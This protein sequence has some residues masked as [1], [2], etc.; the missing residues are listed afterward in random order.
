MWDN[1]E[2]PR[3]SHL[4]ERFRNERDPRMTTHRF[5]FLTGTGSIGHVNMLVGLIRQLK[6]LGHTVGW[7]AQTEARARQLED[8][9][10]DV[11]R[12]QKSSR[13][14]PND[15]HALSPE[16]FVH[17]AADLLFQEDMV[18]P[19][20]DAIR[21]FVPD[22]MAIDC[23]SFVGIVAAALERVPYV[24]VDTMLLTAS[25]MGAGDR[26]TRIAELLKPLR[27]TFFEK[28]GVECTM[29]FYEC[30]SP[31]LNLV[32]S[33]KEFVGGGLDA[34]PNT[35]FVG[36][37]VSMERPDTKQEF[38]WSELEGHSNLGFC[39]LGT[40][41]ETRVP[42][43]FR[44]AAEAMAAMGWKLV[45]S[46]GRLTGTPTVSALPGDPLVVRY[47]PQPVLLRRGCKL[48]IT[49]GGHNS[50]MEALCAGVPM[51]VLPVE[52]DQFLNGYLVQRAGLGL[53]IEAKDVTAEG[54]QDAV[55]ALARPIY[56]QRAKAF[57]EK[58]G[59]LDGSRESANL[60]IAI[61]NQS[62][63]G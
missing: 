39:S 1:G 3:V 27:Q 5:L 23:V 62:S 22:V 25:S 40:L 50:I 19:I 45:I 44:Y 58:Y 9:D 51:L 30:A 32:F 33:T 41:Y 36:P 43:I 2:A 10:V 46:A 26:T 55:K 7:I 14:W 59:S 31:L 60:L 63:S 12:T 37:S 53:T 8:L 15:I 56:S 42:H 24:T 52:G 29:A 6:Q 35:V 34:A 54:V 4:T 13:P 20:R 28:Y 17:V 38:P 21:S 57:A 61:A 48:F 16:A 11:V 49:H 47:V 18:E